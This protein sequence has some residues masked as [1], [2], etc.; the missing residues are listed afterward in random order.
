[1]PEEEQQALSTV[2]EE[3]GRLEHRL[4]LLAYV[5]ALVLC[6]FLFG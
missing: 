3:L 4:A 5:A 1:M 2:Q 6:A